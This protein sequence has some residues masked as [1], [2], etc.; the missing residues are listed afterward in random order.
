M[1][2]HTGR[3]LLSMAA[4]CCACGSDSDQGGAPDAAVSTADAAG[5]TPPDDLAGVLEPVRAGGE[6]PALAAA[7]WRGSTLIAAGATGVR[8]LGAEAAVTAGDRWH[9][10][11]DTKAMTATLIGIHVERGTLDFEDTIGEL[12]AGEEIDPG[13]QDVTVEQL[14]QHRGGAPAD[15][16]ADIWS[17]MWEAGAAPGARE[18]AVLAMLARPP[19]QAPGTFVYSNAGYMM[20]GAALERTVGAGWDQLM[21]DELF[22]PLEMASCGFG[23]PGTAALIDQPWGHAIGDG[24]EPVPVAPGPQADN[25]PSL[26]P[27]G[28]VHC[29][30]EDW[31]AF[32]ALHLA[33]ARQEPT[34]LLTAATLARLQA[35]AA[36]GDYAAGW[37]VVERDWA[38]G[39]ALTHSG[40]NT[41][42]FATT[43]LAPAND[44]TYAVVTNRGDDDAAAA[45]D[46][47]FAPLI[48]AYP[49]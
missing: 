6:L 41:M 44:I 39:L 24:G 49:Q 3:L 23:A 7:V 20:A 28:T 10:G 17:A 34:E 16:P 8:K 1:P 37:V 14:R 33:G 32:L 43:W 21:R 48:D 18:E 46:S 31:G 35:P 15:I 45:V 11:S 9:L 27:A 4:A 38:G 30:L 25:P 47:A 36:G 29:S 5:E 42:W 2:V 26:G 22:E 12:F 13:Y 40:S 19:A